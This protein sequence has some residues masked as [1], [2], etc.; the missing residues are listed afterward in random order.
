MDLLEAWERWT[1]L[2]RSAPRTQEA[3]HYSLARFA[4]FG[5]RRV[6][7]VSLTRVSSYV[8][9]RLGQAGPS[10]TK[11]DLAALCS[12][13]GVLVRSGEFPEELLRAIR[14]LAPEVPKPRRLSA[15][16]LTRTELELLASAAKSEEAEL[17]IRVAAYSGMR[18]SELARSRWEDWELG[19][20]PFVRVLIVPELGQA[21]RIKTGNERAIPVCAELKRALVAR[22]EP[23]GYLFRHG[24]RAS[25]NAQ[26]TVKTL[27]RELTIARNKV[28]FEF[29][30]FH[31]LRH[32]RASWWVQAGVSMAKIAYWLGNT[33]EVCERYYAALREG[34]DPECERMPAA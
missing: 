12:P 17:M 21:G 4:A 20:E 7:D 18:A 2:R 22:R 8:V 34:Y 3:Y 16:H 30:T 32:T 15:K 33:L 31:V 25:K 23:S 13:L 1:I 9:H 11:V 10:S 19:A 24:V 29:A 27:R 26:A 14:R 5:I 6:E 28:G